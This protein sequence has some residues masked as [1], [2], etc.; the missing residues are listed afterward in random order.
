MND[1]VE[2]ET[3]RYLG[4]VWSKR[5]RYERICVALSLKEI[6]VSGHRRTI[7]SESV[8]LLILLCATSSCIMDQ[9][10]VQREVTAV[11]PSPRCVEHTCHYY[12]KLGTNIPILNTAIKLNSSH[13]ASY[14]NR[15]TPLMDLNFPTHTL[16]RQQQPP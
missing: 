6:T 13:Y 8:P 14:S 2:N 4:E 1:D 7:I 5:Q 12:H 15:A 11:I 3:V 16:P 9:S 10:V